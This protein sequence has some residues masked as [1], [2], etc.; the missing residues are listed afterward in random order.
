[1]YGKRQNRDRTKNES[2]RKGNIVASY[3]RYTNDKTLEVRTSIRKVL[4][5][6]KGT[7][8]LTHTTYGTTRTREESNKVRG[9]R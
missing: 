2:A 4:V 5:R 1:M 7:A 9:N 3:L 6:V 8:K